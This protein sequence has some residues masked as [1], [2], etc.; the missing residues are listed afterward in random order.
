MKKAYQIVVRG[1]VQGVGFRPYVF[2]LA[3]ICHLTGWVKNTQKGVEIRIEGEEENLKKFIDLFPQ[4]VPSHAKIFS[5]FIEEVPLSHFEHFV[6]LKGERANQV[7]FDLLPDL[8]ICE[9]CLRELVDP[10]DRRFEYPFITCTLCGPRFSVIES[11]P[12]ERENTTMKYFPLCE[13]CREEYENPEN[14]RFHAETTA[15]PLCGPK[16]KL[17]NA[18]RILIAEDRKALFRAQK[19]IEEGK[20]LALKGLTGFHLIARADDSLV[21]EILRNRKLRKKKPFAVMVK[22]ISEAEKYVFLSEKDKELLAAPMA[23]ILI[24]PSKGNLPY[25][26]NEGLKELGIFLPYT[27]LH[28]LLL[29]DLP[30]PIICTS[31]NLSEEPLLFENDE[32]FEK[33]SKIAD[34][35]LVHNRPIKRPLDDSVIKKSGSF[36]IMVRRG[37]GYTPLPLHLSFEVNKPILAVGAHEKNTIA[38]AFQNKIIV[39][40]H[41]GDL[42]KVEVL[43][44]FKKTIEDFLEL[45]KINPLIIVADYHPFYA[46]TKWAIQ[47]GNE[48]GIPVVF[49]Q[50]HIAHLYSVLAEEGINEGKFLGIAWDGTGYGLDHTIWGGEFFY[51]NGTQYNRVYTF[52]PY[53]LLG[54][55]RAIKDIRRTAL[56]ILLEIF[57]EEALNLPL[58]FLKTFEEKEILFL[59]KAWKE[60]INS[61]LTSSVGRL[62]D[63]VSAL[64]ALCYNNTYSGEAAMRLESLY[65]WDIKENF[66]FEVLDNFYIDWEPMFKGILDD[67]K[68]RKEPNIIATKFINTLA[69]VVLDIA[70]RVSLNSICLSG[71]VMM[72][73]PLVQRLEEL[74]TKKGFSIYKNK[75][76]PPNDGG[77]S[78][79]QAYF[80]ALS[81]RE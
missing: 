75:N 6:I 24:L 78:L 15:C 27:P 1:I 43:A 42:D 38:L 49:V 7:E 10:T 14:R 59:F 66:E 32:A 63:A 64:L 25:N 11:L 12:Y 55:E 9:D 13:R 31:G 39:S 80:T 37:R 34:L 52:R 29:K 60:G 20:I 51:L 57:G 79:G 72:N 76:F 3:K 77:L 2:N 33:L 17:Y 56:S 28:Y 48:R 50:H 74:L 67:L 71:G 54:G 69:R 35:F 70:E 41:I 23:P 61:P 36:Y 46:S 19:A 65:S 47:W 73:S 21:I 62:F 4:R 40:Q 53:K 18:Q 58:P 45:Y 16:I 68:K 22:N 30:F 8:G 5:L 26:L 44:R 81:L